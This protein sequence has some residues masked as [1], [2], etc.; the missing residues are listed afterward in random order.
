V[1]GHKSNRL[2][3]Q[4]FSINIWAGIVSDCFLVPY[5]LP[6][7]LTGQTYTNFLRTSLPDFLE[8]MPPASRR[9]LYFMHDGAPHISVFLPA[10]YPGRWIARGGRNIWPPRS[11]DL[12]PLDFYVWGHV[13]SVM[14]STAVNDVQTLRARIMAACHTV[15]TAPGIFDRVR[16]S[17]RR[18]AEACIQAGGGH[19][20][21]F[22]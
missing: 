14:Y 17:M 19:F 7:R 3:Q 12:N 22:I 2:N 1:G 15:R 5:I 8:V 4:R 11:P 21:R 13:K 18:R 16:R 20:E 6:D 10:H 9:Q